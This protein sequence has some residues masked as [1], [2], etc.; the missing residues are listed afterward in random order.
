VNNGRVAGVQIGR[1]AGVDVR[2]ILMEDFDEIE[3]VNFPKEGSPT[4]Q[5]HT[6]TS[7]RLLTY[8]PRAFRYAF[9]PRAVLRVVWAPKWNPKLCSEPRMLPRAVLRVVLAPSAE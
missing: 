6:S 9:P 2:D 1:L 5:A 4:T 7:F 3:D 8:A